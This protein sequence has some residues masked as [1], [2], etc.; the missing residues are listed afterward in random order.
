MLMYQYK[1]ISRIIK[2]LF[3]ALLMASPIINMERAKKLIVAR[4]RALEEE[5]DNFGY[6]RFIYQAKKKAAPFR[7]FTY[8][9]SI[10]KHG[11]SQ[12]VNVE[13][14][15]R[16]HHAGDTN[17]SV[18]KNTPEGPVY[19]PLK[20][21]EV[22]YRCTVCTKVFKI[23][24]NCLHHIKKIHLDSKREDLAFDEKPSTSQQREIPDPISFQTELEKSELTLLSE[25]EIDDIFAT[26]KASDA[27]QQAT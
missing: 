15:I 24:S 9:C 19:I 17:A 6:D 21:P 22:L 12:R 18:I 11:N 7:Y 20:E 2:S 23:K 1:K 5:K 8:Q 26:I 4:K 13:K 27:H 10:C 25:A 16:A 14:H 3:F